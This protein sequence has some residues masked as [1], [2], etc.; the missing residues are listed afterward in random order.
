MKIYNAAGY[1]DVVADVGGWFTDGSDPAAAGSLF[2]GVSPSRI[3]D[4]RTGPVPAGSAPGKLCAGC[5]LA[6]PVAGFGGVPAMTAPVKPSAVVLNVTITN[7]TTGSYLTVWPNGSSQPVAS[8]LNCVSGLTV[9]NLVVVK[10]GPDGAVN[11]YNAAGS[12]DVIVDVVGWY[13]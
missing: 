2:V 13:G 11:L 5:T 3:L 12:V 6:L 9:P 7:P 10:L 1:V 4:T 8:D